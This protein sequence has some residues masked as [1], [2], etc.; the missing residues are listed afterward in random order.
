MS[1]GGAIVMSGECT[2]VPLT[3]GRV[4]RR[5]TGESLPWERKALAAVLENAPHGVLLIEADGRYSFANE[6]FSRM[7]GYSLSDIPKECQWLGET[8]AGGGEQ[9]ATRSPLKPHIPPENGDHCY[10]LRCR[11]GLVK[12]FEVRPVVLDDGRVIVM[13]SDRSSHNQRGDVVEES[14][15]RLLHTMQMAV[16]AMAATM[17]V[18]DPYTAGHQRRVT[19]LACSVGEE[20]GLSGENTRGLR[21]A[22]SIHDIGKIGMPAELLVMPP[23]LNSVQY[24]LLKEH[25]RIG[26]DILRNIDFPWPIAEIILQHHENLDGSGYP[27]GLRGDRI[28]MEARIIRVADVLEAMSYHRPY[29]PALGLPSALEEIA[30]NRGVLYDG[31]VVDICTRL[32]NE[33]RIVL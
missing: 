18:R 24:D 10:A 23:R 14:Q 2:V 5:Q 33:C 3:D 20:L 25:P 21:L 22:A 9:H 30:T 32:C 17:E 29:R 12:E 28:L 19:A 15:A 1:T 16:D 4:Y 31:D 11:N 27:Q 13:L 26:Y 7:T 6:R 8:C